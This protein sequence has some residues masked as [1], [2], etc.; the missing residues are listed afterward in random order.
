MPPSQL[1]PCD[2]LELDCEGVEVEIL[3]GMIIQPRVI[4]VETHGMY[5]AP[6][7]L[8]ASLLEQR[9]YAVSDPGWEQ[10]S[11][12]RVLLAVRLQLMF[13]TNCKSSCYQSEDR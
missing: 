6:A 10:R 3:R 11:D 4:L 8:I 2:L 9:G 13:N 7:D 12:L 1:P 5:G